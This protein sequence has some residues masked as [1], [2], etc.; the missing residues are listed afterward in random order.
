MIDFITVTPWEYEAVLKDPGDRFVLKTEDVRGMF[1]KYVLQSVFFE[2]DDSSV[3]ILAGDPIYAELISKYHGSETDP[4]PLK[5]SDK[6]YALEC[7]SYI[8]SAGD[9]CLSLLVGLC[10]IRASKLKKTIFMDK[11]LLDEITLK[12]LA[13]RGEM[14]TI[15]LCKFTGGGGYDTI[16]E[17]ADHITFD[18]RKASELDPSELFDCIC[19]VETGIIPEYINRAREVYKASMSREDRFKCFFDATASFALEEFRDKVGCDL[20]NDEEHQYPAG[21]QIYVHTQVLPK[22]TF[23]K[24]PI[25]LAVRRYPDNSSEIENI[26]LV[27]YPAICEMME[28]MFAD[29]KEHQCAKAVYALWDM[30]VLYGFFND[31]LDDVAL[32]V[33]VDRDKKELHFY[34]GKNVYGKKAF[35]DVCDENARFIRT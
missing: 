16:R 29:A 4:S 8:T 1:S 9:I 27:K 17:C 25:V 32:Y 22:E 13:N 26:H 10:V 15:Y 31:V 33:E 24:Y 23:A 5:V 12:F 6:G 35:F 20:W 28:G 7:D 11:S 18:G 21:Y 30:E 19:S 3:G 14:Y 34:D 2:D